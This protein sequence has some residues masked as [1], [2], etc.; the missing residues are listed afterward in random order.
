MKSFYVSLIIAF[1]LLTPALTANSASIPA[2]EAN[3]TPVEN[4]YKK[5]ASLKIKDI[6]KLTGKKFTLKE[7]IAILIL[8]HKIKRQQKR[9]AREEKKSE[10]QTAFTFGIIALVLLIAGLFLPYVILGSLIAAIIAIVTGSM[11]KKKD[12]ND[13]KAHAGKLMG[14]ITLGLIALLLALA[15]ALLAAW[16]W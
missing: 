7:K 14:W 4:L 9:A 5:I 11:A 15:V 13:R 8:K 10:G 12:P 16:G 6:Q 3:P 1:C 2:L